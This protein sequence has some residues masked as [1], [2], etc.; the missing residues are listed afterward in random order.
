MNANEG[1]SIPSLVLLIIFPPSSQ[2]FRYIYYFFF[3]DSWGAGERFLGH[4]FG[5]SYISPGGSQASASRSCSP[6][7]L[8]ACCML[9]PG[10]PGSRGMLHAC[11]HV[12]DGMPSSA[13]LSRPGWLDVCV[14]VCLCVPEVVCLCVCILPYTPARKNTRC[15]VHRTTRGTPSLRAS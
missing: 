1:L 13:R 12:K 11:M 7:S 8:P 3:Q 15:P 14:C 10:H 2:M 9:H 4:N 5:S 6:A